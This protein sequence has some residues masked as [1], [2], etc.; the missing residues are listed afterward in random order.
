MPITH[1]TSLSQLDGILSKAS[2][3]LS[4]ID[5]HAEWCG[6]CHMIAPKYE[7]LSKQYNHVNFLK[8]DV[9]AAKDV[10]S[11][12]RVTAMPTFVF[13]RG[14]TKVDQVRGANPGAL[15][16]TLHRHASGSSSGAFSGKGQR[17]GDTPSAPSDPQPQADAPAIF[18]AFA[19]L[20]PKIKVL[21][22]L[23]AGYLFLWYIS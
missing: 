18:T 13:L 5:F 23:V 17:L 22:Y 14:S 19:Q 12:Y 9:D 10:A 16:E 11:R 7:A 4:V 6:P 2:D 20:D 15:Q 3:K 21:V 8:C 1:I